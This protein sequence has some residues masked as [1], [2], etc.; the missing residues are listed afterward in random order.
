[1]IYIKERSQQQTG[2]IIAA[3]VLPQHDIQGGSALVVK[4]K[5]EEEQKK[6]M[7][8]IAKAVKAD[9]LKLSNGIYLILH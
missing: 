4:A 7:L 6:L 8:D 2:N 9:V 5:D 1:M 3:V